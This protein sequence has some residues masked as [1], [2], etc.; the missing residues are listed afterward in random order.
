MTINLE[1]N[2]TTLTV[3]PEGRVATNTAPILADKLNEALGDT[4][5]LVFDFSDV[6]YISSA[7]LRVLLAM[8]QKMDER[9]G[10][11][12]VLNANEAVMQV[13]DMAGFFAILDVE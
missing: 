12:K 3:K 4:T 5:N 11:M 1:K 7:G 9:A 10:A 2:G 8:Q 6:E 13:F